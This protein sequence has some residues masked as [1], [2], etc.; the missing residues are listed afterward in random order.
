M[1]KRSRLGM[2]CFQ[3]EDE[4]VDY[5]EEAVRVLQTGDE[6]AASVER[7]HDESMRTE[8]V[9]KRE[10]V[11]V[12]PSIRNRIPGRLSLIKQHGVLFIAW[13][14]LGRSDCKHP[15]KGTSSKYAL[16]PTPLSEV[17]A[18]RCRPSVTLIRAAS[19][20]IVRQDGLSLP[21]LVFHKGGLPEL[22]DALN[23]NLPHLSKCHGEPSV[24]L[25]NETADPF[26][27]QLDPS[28]SVTEIMGCFSVGSLTSGSCGSRNYVAERRSSDSSPP[29]AMG[30]LNVTAPPP[31]SARF[32]VK[33]LLA[34]AAVAK[35]VEQIMHSA[36]VPSQDIPI[37]TCSVARTLDNVE[38]VDG[39]AISLQ[40]K[41]SDE[42][43]RHNSLGSSSLNV[44]QGS[45]Q[46][47]GW[48]SWI[49]RVPQRLTA[50]AAAA[51]LSL[52]TIN[53]MTC[54]E[55]QEEQGLL[56]EE[57]AFMYSTAMAFEVPG[58]NQAADAAVQKA[59]AATAM[60]APGCVVGSISSGSHTPC[61]ED[62]GESLV[63]ALD[64]PCASAATSSH[65]Q[66]EEDKQKEKIEGGSMLLDEDFEMVDQSVGMPSSLL[67]G[68]ETLVTGPPLSLEE[69]NSLLDN[70]GR[71][72]GLDT[73]RERVYTSG[74]APGLR[75]VVWKF[76]LGVFPLSS[77]RTEQD[78]LIVKLKKEYQALRLQSES[79]GPSQAFRFSGWRERCTQINKDARR[80]D[81]K[82]EF[83]S[84][85]ANVCALR[86][87]LLSYAIYNF[88]LGYCQGMSD[89]ASPLL[90]VMEDEAEAFW[91][92]AALMDRMS[93][94]FDRCQSGV[95]AQLRELRN[96][97]Q[98]LDPPLHS[99]LESL[100]ALG[101][102][103]A[104][105]WLLVSFKREL[106]SMNEVLNL[107]EADW[108]CPFTTQ[109][110]LYFAAAVLVHHRRNLME[111]GKELDELLRLCCKLSGTL[112]LRPLLQ[113]AEQLADCASKAGLLSSSPGN[114]LPAPPPLALNRLTKIN[115]LS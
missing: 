78:A 110:P 115:K 70:D 63:H 39:S 22:L 73:L 12:W 106:Q 92:F 33:E 34:T 80:T 53:D 98:V 60:T 66:K 69:W 112:Q 38:Q 41:E 79:I 1:C 91:C 54:Q 3:N 86:R 51:A 55:S 21:P 81:R 50:A 37:Q 72:E 14:P 93:G 94:C 74:L 64:T 84:K 102:F 17:R 13:L 68:R 96:L 10:Q 105:R 90:Y 5:D 89:I 75:R 42:S 48:P 76:L 36:V 7:E 46:A 28:E 113:V 65:A 4:E 56:G 16:H 101:Y 111:Q 58:V 99:H 77:T 29:P 26:P 8:I 62:V 59:Q 104:F 6:E 45:R 49:I 23:K 57:D 47:L 97:M 103:F 25:V 71:L 24:Y 95:Q 11:A 100:D 82:L 20:V 30:A 40:L 9:Y 27:R 67:P 114:D 35:D 85:G 87:I 31:D 43:R 109:L 108:A 32:S 83:Y 2:S 107:W 61:T 19:L 88:D 44:T 15:T 52:L 18:L